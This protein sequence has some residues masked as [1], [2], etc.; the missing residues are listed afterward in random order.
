MDRAKLPKTLGVIVVTHNSEA[1]I[2]Q[3]LASFAEQTFR[4]YEAFLIDSGSADLQYIKKYNRK[5]GLEICFMPNIGF[6]AANNLGAGSLDKEVEYVLFLNPD[7]VMPPTLFQDLVAWMNAHPDVGAV[8]PKLLGYDFKKVT[9][10]GKLDSAGIASTWYGK[11]FDRGQREPAELYS[12]QEEVEAICGAFF[13]AR[14]KAL[15][16][17]LIHNYEIFDESFFSYKEDIDLSLRLKNAGWKLVY[18]PQ[19]IA[20]HGRGW[21]TRALV[22]YPI[23]VMSAENELKLHIKSKNPIRIA[24][25][26][27]KLMGVKLFNL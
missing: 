7:V 25:S 3:T 10:T 27:L 12:K 17:V 21:K 26:F 15:N 18:L 2:D 6:S 9:P 14:R 5:M 16:S 22:P 8:T 4:P 23:R 20:Y 11:W 19:F 13:F 1:T 24:Y